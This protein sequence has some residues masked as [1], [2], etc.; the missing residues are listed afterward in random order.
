MSHR[1]PGPRNIL[2]NMQFVGYIASGPIY[3][4]N[5]I[6]SLGPYG[7]DRLEDF[8]GGG[9]HISNHQPKPSITLDMDRELY[10]PHRRDDFNALNLKGTKYVVYDLWTKKHARSTSLVNCRP[11]KVCNIQRT[12]YSEPLL[13]APSDSNNPNWQLMTHWFRL[14]CYIEKNTYESVWV[15]TRNEKIPIS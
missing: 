4:C 2:K 1:R 11:T 6:C 12:W 5:V 7:L 13:H 8:F 10:W 15:C 9:I 14:C 3:L